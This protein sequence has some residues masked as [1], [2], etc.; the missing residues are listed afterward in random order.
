MEAI[1]KIYTKNE[2][3]EHLEKWKIGELSKKAYAK[4]A[5][6]KPTTFYNWTNETKNKKQDFVE[7]HQGKISKSIQ[8]IVIEKGSLTIR[9]PQYLGIKELQTLFIALSGVQ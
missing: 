7:I 6:I 4:S 1:M 2:K 3:Q 5:G 9:I 8:E